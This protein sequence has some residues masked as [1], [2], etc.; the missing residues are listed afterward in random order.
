[1]VQIPDRAGAAETRKMQAV[2][3]EALGDIAGRVEPDHEKRHAAG[4][5]PLQRRQ[6]MA[7]LLEA[8]AKTSGKHAE[9]VTESLGRIGEC[10][11]RQQHGAREIIDEPDPDQ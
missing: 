9:I 3:A 6:A 5:R 11:V 8:R 7:D 10:L 1:M 2:R 4:T